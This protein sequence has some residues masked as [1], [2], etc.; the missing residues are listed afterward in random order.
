MKRTL[1]AASLFA[2]SIRLAGA[3]TPAG[4]LLV[5]NKGDRTLSLIDPAT[6]RQIAVVPEEGVTGHELAASPDGK[7]AFVPIYGDAGVGKVGSDGQLVRVID[8]E[9]RAIVG[10][11]DFGKGVR[12]HCAVYCEKNGL[13]YVTTENNQ[14][15]SI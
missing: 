6:N 1:L 3:E 12:P 14:T 9:K 13:L 15:V 4:T 7:R 2:L 10:T 5:T 11:V 8:L